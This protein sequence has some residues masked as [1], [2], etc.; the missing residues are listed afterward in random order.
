MTARTLLGL[1]AL[2]VM[3][4]VSLT[5]CGE[6]KN[7]DARPAGASGSVSASP[8]TP[9]ESMAPAEI[10][11]KSRLAMTKLRSFRIKG[12]AIAEGRAMTL[13][14][15]VAGKGDCLGT[16]GIGGGTG[17]VR[18]HGGYTYMKGDR[19]FWQASVGKEGV[20]SQKTETVVGLLAGRWLRKPAGS[21]GADDEFPFCDT[22]VMF[23]K[24][25][26]DNSL[27]R[28]V[29][30]D[31][32]GMRGV[33]LTGK[34]GAAARTL[35]VATEGQPYDLRMSVEGG[36]EPQTF[37]FSGFNKPVTLTPP[38]TKNVIDM[39]KLQG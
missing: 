5:A 21:S 20:S 31:V 18:W 19:K 35:V 29:D 24:D 17:Q 9:F 12:T 13:D 3:A 39:D 25:A 34:D 11:E 36:K 33:T 8:M 2:C 32:N 27:T 10:A 26:S 14:V 37:E 15:A 30:T 28:G 1:S 23:T 16:L 6:G 38:P 4:A 22:A 7:A